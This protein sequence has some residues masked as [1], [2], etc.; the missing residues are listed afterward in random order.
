MKMVDFYN[1]VRVLDKMR[2]GKQMKLDGLPGVMIVQFQ[3]AADAADFIATTCNERAADMLV[4]VLEDL[5]SLFRL[6]RDE[7]ADISNW[8]WENGGLGNAM[9]SAMAL[10]DKYKP[11]EMIEELLQEVAEEVIPYLN[12]ETED[13]YG[14]RA[15]ADWDL[16][17]MTAD[18]LQSYA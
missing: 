16:L 10:R 7:D 17:S 2:T 8:D 14:Y 5:I 11:D 6:A 9:E 1:S 13:F 4:V 18:V 12:G 3:Q 15:D